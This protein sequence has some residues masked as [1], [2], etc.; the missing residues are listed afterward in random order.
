MK[1]KH[2]RTL[3]AIYDVQANLDWS[4]IE[5][6]FAELGAQKREHAGSRVRFRFPDGT[7]AVFHVPHPASETG[8]ATVRAV[9]N[10]LK[11]MGVEP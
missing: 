4:D 1:R 9:M 10:V 6:L 2:R 7:R 8:R 3:R 11:R 5:G